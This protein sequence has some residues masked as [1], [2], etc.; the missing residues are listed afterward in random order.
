MRHFYLYI[1]L[2]STCIACG[3]NK[4]QHDTSTPLSSK[5]LSHAKGFGID[6]FQGYNRIQVFNPWEKGKVVRN[7]YIVTDSTIDSSTF[8]G[9]VIDAIEQIAITSCTHIEFLNMLDELT[10][11][12]G[13]CNPELIYNES[14]TTRC[15]SGEIMSLGDAFNTNIERLLLLKPN[16]IMLSSYNQQDENAKRIEAAGIP[17]IFNNEWM[18]ESVLGRAEWIKFIAQF[19]GK[20]TLAD[21]LYQIIEENYNK[22]ISQV[23]FEN[24][25]PSI[26]VG[27]NFKGTWYMPSGASY[28]G[29]L[30]KD[31]GASYYYEQ[32][33]TGGS[34][35][36]NFETVLHNFA[37][38]Q[39][40][41]NAPTQTLKE[42]QELDQRHNLFQAAKQNR[43]YGFYNRTK[44][45]GANDFWE[46]G[47]A[48]PDIVLQDL[49]WALYPETMK[50]YQPVYI[51][52]LH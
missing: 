6:Y 43:V 52:Q 3:S 28:M 16:A 12:T 19:F 9:T 38:S 50:D 5:Q 17:I 33:S 4:G 46:S 24:L 48:H 13:V 44:E 51:I 14:L 29:R 34:L 10:S 40:W 7:Y 36:L 27:G 30:L 2:L 22:A 42:L 49:I 45:G 32:D 23:E 8:Q 25:K 18:E 37:N 11:V 1:I 26:M 15:E 41:L 47:V 20:E 21:S 39:V 31:A 35:A